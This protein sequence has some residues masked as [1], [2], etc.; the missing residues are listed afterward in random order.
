MILISFGLTKLWIEKRHEFGHEALPKIL[1]I[2]LIFCTLF[3]FGRHGRFFDFM[4]TYFRE[5]G[6]PSIPQYRE[7]VK[8]IKSKAR[9]QERADSE[10]RIKKLEEDVDLWQKRYFE[11]NDAVADLKNLGYAV[12][13]IEK[14]D[15]DKLD[16]L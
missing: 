16:K 11:L 7:Q 4:R 2:D 9:A 1:Q 14:F 13:R 8:R 3:V 10:W 5:W 12:R 6:A 15:F